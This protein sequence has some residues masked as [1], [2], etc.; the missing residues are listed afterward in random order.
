[1]LDST[2]CAKEKAEVLGRENPTP[3]GK[4]GTINKDEEEQEQ[5]EEE[6]KEEEQEGEEEQQEQE[7]EEGEEEE[8]N[9]C[10]T[11]TPPLPRNKLRNKIFFNSARGVAG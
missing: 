9:K 3:A 5:K 10:N 8:D 4:L 7:Q 6:Q 2:S 1:M 11:F